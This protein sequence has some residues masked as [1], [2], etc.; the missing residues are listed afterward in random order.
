MDA[1]HYG[2]RDQTT[3]LPSSSNCLLV[4]ACTKAGISALFHQRVNLFEHLLHA[5]ADLFPVLAQ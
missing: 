2:H 5:P 4:L 1:T 3:V